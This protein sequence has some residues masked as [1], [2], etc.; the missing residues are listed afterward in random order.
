M[1]TWAVSVSR[2]RFNVIFSP[3]A[4]PVVKSVK[5]RRQPLGFLPVA[6][7]KNHKVQAPSYTFLKVNTQIADDGLEHDVGPIYSNAITTPVPHQLS[8]A[9]RILW[10]L[11]VKRRAQ[12]PRKTYC[13][14]WGEIPPHE[15]FLVHLQKSLLAW[16]DCDP[17]H[18]KWYQ[19]LECSLKCCATAILIVSSYGSIAMETSLIYSIKFRHRIF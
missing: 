13:S 17:I 6:K 10:C 4:S 18:V 16:G 8:T 9:A 1:L 2:N 7:I 11:E 5:W 3:A 14:Q 12:W 15:V 19:K